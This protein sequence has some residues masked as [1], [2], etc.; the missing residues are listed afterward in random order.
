MSPPEY[1]YSLRIATTPEKLWASL[2]GPDFWAQFSG[3]VETDWQTGSP[4]QY[5]LPSGQLYAEGVILEARPPFVLSHTWPD[6]EP[7][8]AGNK[9]QQLTWKIELAEPGA[10]KLTLLHENLTQKA[11]QGVSQGWPTILNALKA[12]L[13]T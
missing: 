12:A 10:V 1:L 9:I 11:Y 4:I 8:Q 13:E 2:T 7:E 3:P 5:F 6:P